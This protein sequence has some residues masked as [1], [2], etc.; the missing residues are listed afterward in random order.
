MLKTETI[1]FF[2]VLSLAV[3]A[4][5]YLETPATEA[6]FPPKDEA[7]IKIKKGSFVFVDNN[8]MTEES[9]SISSGSTIETTKT[10]DAQILIGDAGTL[11]LEKRTR[12]RLNYTARETLVILENGCA[13]LWVEAGMKG[14]IK[15]DDD[16]K[17]IENNRRKNSIEI[18]SD[19]RIGGILLWNTLGATAAAAA[20]GGTTAAREPKASA[21]VF[22]PN[23]A[24]ASASSTSDLQ[25]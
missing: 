19:K 22:F 9:R 16:E 11:Q 17:S 21:G 15:T 10:A 14:S 5:F 7:S 1:I 3:F 2:A 8:K 24:V 4:S 12:V 18:C 23:P 25:R 6:K 20:A 13:T